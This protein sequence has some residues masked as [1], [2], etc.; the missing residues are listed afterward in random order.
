MKADRAGWKSVLRASKWT[1]RG[2]AAPA[3]LRAF[4]FGLY[5]ESFGPGVTAAGDDIDE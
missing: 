4:L 2:L 5:Q 1:G 3:P